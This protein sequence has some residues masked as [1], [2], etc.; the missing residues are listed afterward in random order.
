LILFII[1]QISPTIGSWNQD[2]SQFAVGYVRLNK[3]I[4]NE[5]SV[6]G[7]NETVEVYLSIENIATEPIFNVFFNDTFDETLF[8][9]ISA[10]NTTSQTLTSFNMSWTVIQPG[11]TVVVKTF[12]KIIANASKESVTIDGTNVTLDAGDFRIPTYRISNDVSIEILIPQQ[13]TSTGIQIIIGELNSDV[14]SVIIFIVLPILVVL[15]LS[16]I[17][18]LRKRKF[19]SS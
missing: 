13:T 14:V 11:E 17:F 7:E 18:G 5:T 10:S 4:L 6:F 16:F 15:L 19:E 9:I 8:E 3:L 2:P 1:P 12:L